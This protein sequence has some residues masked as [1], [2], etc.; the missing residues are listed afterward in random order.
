ME[1][2]LDDAADDGRDDA[3][4]D[5]CAYR[6]VRG[7]PDADPGLPQTELGLFST[8]DLEFIQR[9]AIGLGLDG[10]LGDVESGVVAREF[11]LETGVDDKALGTSMPFCDGTA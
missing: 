10:T 1:L 11:R 9:I 6:G 5:T 7:V 8:E 3:R 4:G 2:R